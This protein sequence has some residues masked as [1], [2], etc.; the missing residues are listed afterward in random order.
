M[1]HFYVVMNPDKEGARETS[2][3]ICRYLAGHGADCVIGKSDKKENQS[4]SHYT[5]S[6]VVP[7][8]TDCIITLGG[9]GTLIQ[10]ARDLAGRNI[11]ILGINRGTLGYL[12]QISRSEEMDQALSALISGDYKLEE[13]MMLDGTVRRR[14]EPIFCDI[15]LNE[16]V[17]IRNEHL[18]VLKFKV[19][20]NG[21]YF[22][23]YRADGLIAAT[24]TGSTAYNLSA[25]GPILVPD[26][27]MVALTPICSHV[28]GT[29]S[30][31]LSSDD[32]IQVEMLGQDEICQAAVFDGDTQ[33]RLYP[34][35]IIEIGRSEIKT[36]L[37]KLKNISFLD[38]LRNKMTGI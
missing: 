23:E 22:N 19:Y 14:G 27:K 1:R 18:K 28:L 5:D 16:I 11:P 36:I 7:E 13:R 33:I 17:I 26:S 20:V 34:G 10:A 6:S 8:N 35:D 15:A 9:D 38:N 21:E 37:V 24:P 32:C 25:G 29:R 31:V 4:G 30:I 12:T 2:E 3:A